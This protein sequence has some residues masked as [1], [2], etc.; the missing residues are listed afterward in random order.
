MNHVDKVDWGM[1]LELVK[2]MRFS[3]KNNVMIHVNSVLE[4][5]LQQNVILN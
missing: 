5:P 2:I 1:Q 4:S 3:S